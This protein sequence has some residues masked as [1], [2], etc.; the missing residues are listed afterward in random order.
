MWNKETELFKIEKNRVQAVI[1][2]SSDFMETFWKLART[3]GIPDRWLVRDDDLERFEKAMQEP[4]LETRSR[5]LARLEP[6]MEY[7]PPYWYVRGRTDQVQGNFQ[8]AG[9]SYA[10]L[11]SLGKGHFRRDEMLAAGLANYALIQDYL[12]QPDAVAIAQRALDCQADVWQANLACAQVLSH[13][14]QIVSAEEAIYRNLDTD[15]EKQASSSLLLSI[16]NQH[17]RQDKIVQKLAEPKFL[18]NVSGP[19]VILAMSKLQAEQIP[20]SARQYLA[21]SFI[22]R[23]QLKHGLDDLVV[24]TPIQWQFPETQLSLSLNN[25][26]A[27]PSEV[28]LKEGKVETRFANLAEFGYPRQ[29]P[30]AYPELKLEMTTAG[31]TPVIMFLKQGLSDSFIQTGPAKMEKKVNSLTTVVTSQKIPSDLTLPYPEV[32]TQETLTIPQ[33]IIP[34][35]IPLQKD[36]QDGDYSIA[37]VSVGEWNIGEKTS[38]SNKPEQITLNQK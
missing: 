30:A 31:F 38:Q 17:N 21:D 29:R 12:G 35:V 6:F 2:K 20:L 18:A 5:M 7:Y 8:P 26:T 3:Q 32:K 9:V 36:Y 23:P 16:Y 34:Q 25:Q 28:N 15:L 11:E 37:G 22:I 10:R 24:V 4:N 1:T 13:A 19:V 27:K 14:T 33:V